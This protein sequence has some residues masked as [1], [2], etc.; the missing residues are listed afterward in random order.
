M[1]TKCKCGGKLKTTY[2]KH[3]LCGWKCIMF[4][5]KSKFEV[6]GGGFFYS[7][8]DAYTDAK[9]KIEQNEEEGYDIEKE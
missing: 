3:P 2:Y 1:A 4:C 9:M 8:R 7:K 5:D 6:V